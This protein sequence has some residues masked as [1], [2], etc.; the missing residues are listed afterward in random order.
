MV[1]ADSWPAIC[2]A[3]SSL[4]P[5]CRY[6]VM[7]VARKLWQLILVRSPA[8]GAR[9]WIIADTLACSGESCR[10]ACVPERREQGSVALRVL[11][12]A[13][14]E[15]HAGGFAR[16]ERVLG[17]RPLVSP[18]EGLRRLFADSPK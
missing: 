2:C 8:A 7:P 14:A 16:S 10:R 15:R 11:P 9:R 13:G 18:N 6:V 4:P 12:G 3:T 17:Y 1:Q 5:F